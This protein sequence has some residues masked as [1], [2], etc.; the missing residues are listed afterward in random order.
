MSGERASDGRGTVGSDASEAPDGLD[1]PD[2]DDAYFDRVSERLMFNYDLEKDR[3][4][5]EERFDLYGELYMENRKQFLHPSI[6]YANH[7][8][9]EHL[10]VRRQ[11]RIDD[12]TL[13]R[14]VSLGRDLA[15]E[16]IEA[17]EEHYGTEFTF[18]LVVPEVSDDDAER[19][20]GFRDRTLLK[21]GYYGH[22][23]INLAVVAPE[24]ETAVG[25]RNT[26]IEEAFA[27]WRPMDDGDDPGL[28]R[29]VVDRLR[30]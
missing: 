14:L 17:D 1:V 4:F 15:D 28:L 22:Y 29:R 30:P 8:V 20:R 13:D 5:R 24:R 21:Y 2:W 10:F 25:S 26:D 18:V 6:N 3:S 7:A 23:E 11:D 16:W 12:A 9:Q 27:V 19:V